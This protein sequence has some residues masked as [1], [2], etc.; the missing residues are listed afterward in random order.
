MHLQS[1][2]ASK[3]NTLMDR[4]LS[5]HMTVSLN[6]INFRLKVKP[7]GDINCSS[8]FFE[9]TCTGH[10]YFELLYSITAC[11][12]TM[13]FVFIDNKQVTKAMSC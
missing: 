8:F 10:Y 4:G 2:K 5:T 7:A 3:R 1:L 6:E 12:L 11:S 13:K 9:D